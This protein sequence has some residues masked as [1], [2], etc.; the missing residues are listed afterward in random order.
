MAT[1][2]PTPPPQSPQVDSLQSLRFKYKGQ[3]AAA[4]PKHI[5]PERMI[6]V[7]MTAVSRSA[8]LKECTINSIAGALVQASIMGLE[9]DGLS[10][11]C[12]LIPFWNSK[13]EIKLPS[14]AVRKGGYE[15]QLQVGYKGLVKL[16]L[17]TGEYA[18]IDAQPVHEKDHFK[19]KKGFEV[20]LE[21]EWPRTG[22]RGPVQGYWAGY[23]LKDGGRNFEYWTVEQV[24]AHR[25]QYSQ[26]A[27]QT[28]YNKDKRAKEFVLDGAGNKILTGPWKDSPDWMCRKTPLKSV[29]KLAPAS[30]EM[31]IAQH[32]D[33]MSESG[34][35]QAFSVEL[36]M[37]LNPGAMEATADDEDENGDD[38]HRSM[39][40][41]PQRKSETQPDPPKEEAK[42]ADPPKTEPKQDPPKTD[43][44]KTDPAKQTFVAMC[45][46]LRDRF[47]MR[48][49]M[50]LAGIGWEA[51]DLVPAA[52]YDSVLID[53]Q[54]ELG[55]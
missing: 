3:I 4:L 32:L 18:M 8:L 22:D 11:Q 36:P 35:R 31:A 1:Q 16:A 10:G 52:R 45:E 12:Y 24:H 37:E 40:L 13:L 39:I 49:D 53:L 30:Y 15:C 51:V 27:F 34:K 17:N 6:R 14:G 38:R 19:A 47:P 5:T 7:G 20:L 50:V 21:H 2:Q 29:L 41:M 26:S 44:P 54:R 55:A 23:L 46:S 25:D 48:F 42:P 9:P 28:R 33:E 43:P